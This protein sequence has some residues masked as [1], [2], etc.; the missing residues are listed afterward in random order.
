M[1]GRKALQH[2]RNTNSLLGSH[3]FYEN[4]LAIRINFALKIKK[5]RCAYHTKTN[6]VVLSIVHVD[7]WEHGL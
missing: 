5:S 7:G 4:V 2:G 1:N 3:N 6:F